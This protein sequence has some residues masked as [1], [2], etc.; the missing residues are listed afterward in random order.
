MFSSSAPCAIPN[1]IFIL[2]K[3]TLVCIASSLAVF[4]DMNLWLFCFEGGMPKFK[5]LVHPLEPFVGELNF[6]FLPFG[7]SF[8]RTRM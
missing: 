1:Q 6:L 8:L 3:W 4:T 5:F 7:F 2:R